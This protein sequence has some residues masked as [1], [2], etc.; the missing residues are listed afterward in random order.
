MGDD[1]LLITNGEKEF[2]Y[3]LKNRSHLRERGG[4]GF[5]FYVEREFPYLERTSRD[6]WFDHSCDEVLD[7]H[8]IY[9][10]Y[11]KNNDRLKSARKGRIPEWWNLLIASLSVYFISTSRLKQDIDDSIRRSREGIE[12]SIVTHIASEIKEQIR[13]A[14]RNQFEE[15]RKKETSFPTRLI[16]A[17][18]NVSPPSKSSV[19]DAINNLQKLEEKYGRL[20][21]IPNAK[22]TQQLNEHLNLTESLGLVVL[23]TYLDDIVQKFSLLNELSDRLDLFCTSVNNFL[24]FKEISTSADD[25]I[26]VHLKDDTENEISSQESNDKRNV[27]LLGLSSGEQHLIVLLGRLIFGT[28]K[29]SLVLIDEPEISFHPEWQ[30]GFLEIINK[31]QDLNSLNIIIATHSY[32]LIGDDHWDNSIDLSDQYEERKSKKQ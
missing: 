13:I 3:S 18:N 15:G 27:P 16:E 2:T 9:F 22:T 20:G 7:R 5:D 10:K 8:D 32:I 21:I 25:G 12:N 29:G 1:E 4:M 14:I 26:I 19:V 31:V 28:R 11:I 6:E 23:K 17:L 30:E 24:S